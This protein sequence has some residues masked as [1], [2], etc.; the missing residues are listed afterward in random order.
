MA[1][2]VRCPVCGLYGLDRRD[3][4]VMCRAARCGAIYPEGFLDRFT[5][6][7]ADRMYVADWRPGDVGELI[8]K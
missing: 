3:G 4:S 1:L 5:K 7:A 6:L 8:L 2:S